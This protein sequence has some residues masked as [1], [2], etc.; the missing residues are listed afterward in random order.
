MS[1]RCRKA[2]NPRPGRE[3]LFRCAWLQTFIDDPQATD[4]ADISMLPD[5]LHFCRLSGVRVLRRRWRTSQRM[6]CQM[7]VVFEHPQLID[8]TPT[9]V[10]NRAAGGASMPHHDVIEPFELD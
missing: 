8:R 9:I 3:D 1:R 7:F 4:A 6:L 2:S 5:R 10:P